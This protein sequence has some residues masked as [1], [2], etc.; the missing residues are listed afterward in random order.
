MRVAQYKL[1]KAEGDTEDG[2]LVVYY[3]GQG[4]GGATQANIDRWISQMHQPDG[5]DSKERAKSET[6]TVKGL[7]VTMVDVTGTYSAEMSPGSGDFTS[8]PN[9]RLRAA[10]VETP[11]G[12][13]FA[14]LTGPEKTISRWDQAFRDYIS[15]FQFK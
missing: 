7:K 4:Q 10:V 14:K 12:S 5:S 2:S 1:P 3:F 15:S 11:K 8:K 13:Y 9:Y 6:L